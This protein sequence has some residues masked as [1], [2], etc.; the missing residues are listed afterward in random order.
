MMGIMSA[1][2]ISEVRALD[3]NLF[4][5]YRTKA[6]DSVAH[7]GGRYLVRGGKVRAAEGTWPDGFTVVVVEFPSM[8]V[9]QTWYESPEYAQALL[10]RRR[11]ALER[12]L[13][14]VDGDTER[15]C[16]GDKRKR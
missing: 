11:G 8:H 16:S 10:A 9:L 2:V 3:P 15:Q 14:F 6:A 7:H 12:R 5:E 13:V 1:Y 4:E